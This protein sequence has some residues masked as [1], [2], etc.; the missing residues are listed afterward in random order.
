M[1]NQKNICARGEV[2]LQRKRFLCFPAV[3]SNNQSSSHKMSST[4]LLTHPLCHLCIWLQSPWEISVEAS[5]Q[6]RCW[7]RRDFPQTEQGL[8]LEV[9]LRHTPFLP[10][11]GLM[12][13]PSGEAFSCVTQQVQLGDHRGSVLLNLLWISSQSSEN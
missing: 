13:E 11:P 8:V 4:S 5:C 2:D 12:Q 6:R 7:L 9:L 1:Q 10:F 3:A